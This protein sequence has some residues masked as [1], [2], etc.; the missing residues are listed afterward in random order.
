[1]STVLLHWR[2][3]GRLTNQPA[4]EFNGFGPATWIPLSLCLSLLPR[5]MLLWCFMMRLVVQSCPTLCDPMD[6]GPPGSSVHEDSPGKNTGVG[7]HVLL[8]GVFPTQGLNPG[9]PHCT[10]FLYHLSHQGSQWIL[11]W[12]AYPF[13]RGR[14]RNQ[15]GISCIAGG[16]FISWSTRKAH[17]AL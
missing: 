14:P 11:D 10:W 12:V 7:C 15:T 2:S 16:F 6:C 8:Q 9:L 17:G 13:S 3:R 4:R 1:M 5:G